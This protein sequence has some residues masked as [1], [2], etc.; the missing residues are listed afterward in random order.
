[1]GAAGT[2]FRIA[3][4]WLAV[5]FVDVTCTSVFSSMLQIGHPVSVLFWP[6]DPGWG[7]LRILDPRSDKHHGSFSRAL[8]KNFFDQKYFNSLSIQC[9]G[10]GMEKSRCGIRD[11]NIK[12]RDKH[13]GSATL[14]FIAASKH[15]TYD[16]LNNKASKTCKTRSGTYRRP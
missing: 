1:M 12:I 11:G 8:T 9:C 13:P 7:K 2:I 4:G 5:K 14:V 6:L 16:F 3:G 10:T 15:L